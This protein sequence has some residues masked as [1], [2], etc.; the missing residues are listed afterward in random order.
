[1]RWSGEGSSARLMLGASA[2]T[3]LGAIPPFLV[4]AQ[5]VLLMR[6]LDFGPA[7][8]GLAVS[9]FFAV[10]A[11]VT[12]L[13]GS[14]LERWGDPA[15]RLVAGLLVATGG[16]G[17]ALLVRDWPSLV[18]AMA[19]L[20]AGNATCQS[21]SNRTVATALPP[22]RRGLG[23]GVKQSAVPAAIMLGGLAVPTTTAALGWRSTFV[24][25][26]L[27]GVLVALTALASALAGRRRHRRTTAARPGAGAGTVAGRGGRHTPEDRDR[28]PWGPLLLC[29]VAITFASAAAN[30]LGAYLASWAHEVGLTIGQAGLLMAAGSGSSVLV[31]VVSG[32]RADARHGGNLSVVAAMMLSGAVCLALIGAVP[33][34]WSVLL[35]GFLAFAVGWSWPGLLLYAVAR[36][37]RDAPTQASSVVQAGA[38][39]GGALGPVGFGLLVAGLGFR[40]AWEAAAAALL[41]AGV[42]TLLARHGFRRDLR[43]R[44]PTEPF[45]Y[46][47]GRRSPRFVTRTPGG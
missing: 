16:L 12:I 9:T 36:V 23:F 32:L 38:F 21:T 4:G 31:R 28:A 19:V 35:F 7:G 15:G 47:G 18:A 40:G 5:A 25:T 44:P 6:D 34:V 45:A 26:G 17:L 46:G 39:V 20:G 2:L 33:Q 1:M 37:G 3:T 30:F 27:L 11:L 43:E 8:L 22:H 41:V 13:G 42:L 14:R 24:V 10:A 29:G